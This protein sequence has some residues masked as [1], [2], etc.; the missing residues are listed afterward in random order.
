MRILFGWHL[1]GPSWPES[2]DGTAASLDTDIV[3]PAG[4]IRILET[5]LALGGPEVSPALR[6]AQYLARLR[7]VDDGQHFYSRSLAA[8]GWSVAR[9]LL[10]WRDSLVE[11]GWDGS[12][13]GGGGRLDTLAEV[14]RAPGALAPGPGDRLRAVTAALEPPR[15]TCLTELRLATP[16]ELLPEP[17]RRLLRRLAAG[18]TAVCPCRLPV[19]AGNGDLAALGRRL[20]GFTE[21]AAW[22]GDGSLTLLEADDEWLAAEAVAGWLAAAPGDN[23]AIAIIRGQR[24][25]LLDEACH[26]L[27]L[28]RVGGAGRSRW[29]AAV[30]VLPLAFATA[31][32]PVDVHRLMELLTLPQSPIPMGVAEFFAAALQKAPGIG[33]PVWQEAWRDALGRRRTRLEERGLAERDIARRLAEEERLWRG[34]L[35]MPRIAEA[36]GIPAQVAAALCRRVA[37]W[38]AG[39]ALQGDEML[40]VV[41]AQAGAMAEVVAASGL[42]RIPKPQIDRML[43]SV[44]ADGA[45]VP[46]GGAEAAPWTVVDEPGQ[47]WGPARAVVWW[48]F[49]DGSAGMAAVPWSGAE[50]AAL[51]AAGCLPEAATQALRRE[52]WA[53]RL[54]VL[55]AAERL[56]LVKPRAIAG[57]PAAAHPLWHEIEPVL[58]DLTQDRLTHGRGCAVQASALLLA[59]RT[60]LAGRVVQR[61][62]L[63]GGRPPEPRRLWRV[64]A[65]AVPMRD[66][67]SA[68]SL[69][70]LLGCPFAWT[71]QY[72]AGVRPGALRRIPDGSQLVGTLTHAV[73]AELFTERPSWS[74]EEAARRAAALFDRLLPVLAAPLLRLGQGLELERARAAVAD[75]ARML[76]G[77]IGGAGLTVRGCEVEFQETLAG[78]MGGGIAG[79]IV[80]DGTVDM[81]LEDETGGPVILDLKWSRTDRHRRQEIAEGRAIQLAVYG[82]LVGG[83]VTTS[84]PAGYFMLAQQRLL[85]TEP[86]PFP[87]H[88]H[89]PGSDLPE[90]W[91]SAWDSR[92]RQLD[93]LRSGEIVAAGIADTG[94][95]GAGPPAIVL[96]PPCRICDYGRLCG[97]GS[98]QP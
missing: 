34:W 75:A 57:E 93:R 47:I 95:D 55:N 72:A 7:A 78:D 61:A 54:P 62:A 25:M 11:A 63:D 14:E 82:R 38:A 45:A 46:A 19:P 76:A 96:T 92:T 85:F 52:A 60:P 98:I 22:R 2:L 32:E 36:D 53:W 21:G 50:R 12:V 48:G 88:A 84:V 65:D 31:W 4:L 81:L 49:L 56:I 3:G 90:V 73:L 16:E 70:R 87:A 37:D 71:L 30:Q 41:A 77:L 79:D 39:R 1:D 69:N 28:P 44:I 91:R 29:R 10:G 13:P 5:I 80:V 58:H 6:I 59:D 18:G 67:E 89:I 23:H 8:D 43:D 64:P 26:R 86:A 83:G 35:E 97:V 40:A 51:A 17:W 27:G 9:M 33:G 94:C 15:P 68:T 66:R 24:T 74:A 42:A 20:G